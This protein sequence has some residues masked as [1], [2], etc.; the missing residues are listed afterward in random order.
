M[1]KA[2]KHMQQDVAEH[3]LDQVESEMAGRGHL[4]PIGSMKNCEI[5][6]EQR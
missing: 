3:G 6:S 4:Y 2:G 1:I 5:V